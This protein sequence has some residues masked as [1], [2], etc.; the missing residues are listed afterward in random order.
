[1]I[2]YVEAPRAWWM[3]HGMARVAGVNLPRAV[4]DGFVERRELAR[5]VNRCQG[6]IQTEACQVWLGAGAR[7]RPLPQWCA[8]KDAI[9]SLSPED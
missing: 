2:G 1:M 9:E 3:A 6:C 5:M 4:L 8:N 7:N